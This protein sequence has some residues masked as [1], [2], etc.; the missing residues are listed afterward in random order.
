[1]ADLCDHL[2]QA[3]HNEELAE[4]LATPSGL[5]YRDW[6][7]TI[8][9]YAAV[10][11]VEAL[12]FTVDGIVHTERAC[13]DHR[14]KHTFREGRV[15]EQLGKNPWESYRELSNASKIARYLPYAM[16]K[17]GTG[18][19]YYEDEDAKELFEHHLGTVRDAVGEHINVS[20]S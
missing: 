12:F 20:P 19:D 2:R 8:A 7:I 17:P 14:S 11:Y 15:K 9:F 6:L 1:M 5:K 4:K 16:G 18:L 13:P 3:W 10:H